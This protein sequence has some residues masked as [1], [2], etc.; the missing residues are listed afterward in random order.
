MAIRCDAICQLATIA[1]VMGRAIAW[2][3]EKEQIVND[4]EAAKLLVRPYR[5]K[6]KVW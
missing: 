5:E 6:W 2:D 4:S 3:P 1:T